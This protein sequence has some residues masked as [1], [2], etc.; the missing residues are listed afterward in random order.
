M[1]Q[2]LMGVVLMMPKIRLIAAVAS[3]LLLLCVAG[4]AWHL[5]LSPASRIRSAVMARLTDPNSATFDDLQVDASGRYGCGLVNAKNRMGGY[6]GFRAFIGGIDGLVE[7]E[8]EAPNECAEP[9]KRA[10]AL[11]IRLEFKKLADALCGPVD[12][13]SRIR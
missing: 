3:A 9:A 4:A 10:V 7:F 1:H 5:K 2:A 12:S 11:Q 6:T 8:P 13:F